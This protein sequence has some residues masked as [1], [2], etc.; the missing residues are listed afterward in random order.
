MAR[1]VPYPGPIRVGS[2]GPAQLAV[3]R[4]LWRAGIWGPPRGG[5][6]RIFGPFARRAVLNFQRRRPALT[7]NGVY[8]RETHRLLAPF[9]DDY[10][11]YLLNQAAA[12]PA[13][14]RRQKIVA[15]ALLGHEKRGVML[16]T[17][18]P[19]RMEWLRLKTRPP[20]VPHW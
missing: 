4:A 18:G 2:R 19:R 9:F 1:L 16:Y 8:T 15:N 14:T 11:V 7:P 13:S 3:K 10:G 6:T 20:E 17:Q 5:F 12:K